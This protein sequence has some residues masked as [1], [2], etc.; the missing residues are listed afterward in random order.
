MKR[1]IMRKIREVLRLKFDLKQ[2]N[3]KIAQ[4]IGVG[5]TTVEQY[6]SRAKRGG[7]SWP[8]PSDMDDERLELA[9]YPKKESSS[10][11]DYPMPDFNYIHKEIKKKG[12]TLQG[13]WEEFNASQKGHSYSQ[14]CLLY[15]R[16]KIEDETWMIQSHKAGVNTFIDYAGLTIPIF[17]LTTGK[18]LFLAQIFVAVLG[19]SS[20]TFAE[21]TRSQGMEDWIGS[22]KRMGVFFGGTTEC[23]IPDNLRSGVTRSNRYEPLMTQGYFS[24]AAHYGASIIPARVRRPQDKSKAEGGVRFVETQIL[25]LLRNRKFFSLEELNEEI[26]RLLILLNNKPFQKMPG[27]SRYSFY[28][29]LE[30]PALKPLPEVPYE[31][32]NWGI[33][34]V[35]PSYHVT[36]AH[37]P[38]SIPFTLVRESVEHRY[39]ERTV[40][41]FFKGK[42]VAIHQRSYEIGIPVT[43]NNHRPPRHQHQAKCT[44]EDI[45]KEAQAIGEFV[46]IWVEKVF[47]DPSLHV[48]QQINTTLGVVRLGK[49]YSSER[50][51][52]ACS[53]GLFY[54]N[55]TYRAIKDILGRGLDQRPLPKAEITKPL[56]QQHSNVRGCNYYQ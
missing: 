11:E 32:F 43:N 3:A 40:E 12:V 30:K 54:G 48:K 4:S 51:N 45:K 14:Y 53:R 26:Q 10:E 25:A 2:S 23:Y 29:E 17:D 36:I 39:N 47:E 34:T 8:L 56:P 44:P 16:W 19:A 20:Y 49:R 9:L 5:E 6:L 21:A 18:E 1:V 31:L 41:F 35:N 50:M 24:L 7:I 52:A 33:T 38:Y 15:K 28:L 22:H 37:V 42:S 13:L 46:S 27:S 55:F